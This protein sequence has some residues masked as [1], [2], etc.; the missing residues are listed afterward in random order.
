[1]EN[2]AKGVPNFISG[3]GPRIAG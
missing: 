2:L 1:V 3:R